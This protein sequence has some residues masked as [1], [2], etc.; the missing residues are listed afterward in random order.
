MKILEAPKEE[1]G[2]LSALTASGHP[3]DNKDAPVSEKSG[4]DPALLS[5]EEFSG[6]IPGRAPL[7]QVYAFTSGVLL[8]AQGTCIP[9]TG[10]DG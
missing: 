10:I 8:G 3:W 9:L 2:G 7:K 1:P 4:S 6:L 5:S